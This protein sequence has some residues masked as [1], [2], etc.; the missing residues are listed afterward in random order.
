M[1][2]EKAVVHQPCSDI[3]LLDCLESGHGTDRVL[4]SGFSHE[5]ANKSDRE[6]TVWSLRCLT[7][8]FVVWMMQPTVSSLVGRYL[9]A[10]LM[11]ALLILGTTTSQADWV[12]K[13]Q[14]L[15]GGRIAWLGCFVVMI[16]TQLAWKPF[17]RRS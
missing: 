8:V 12:V 14:E 16:V 9:F 15:G 5:I 4:G 3:Y 6:G 13:V 11:V 17:K 1:K 7:K 2:L 10:A